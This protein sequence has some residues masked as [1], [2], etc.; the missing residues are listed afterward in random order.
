MAVAP[1]RADGVPRF[2]PGAD[3][4]LD[5]EDEPS[6]GAQRVSRQPQQRPRAGRNRRGCPPTRSR[7]T[8]GGVA[9]V[10][11][12]LAFDQFV[13]DIPGP[14]LGDHRRGQV[15]SHQSPRIRRDERSAQPGA[16]SGI[17]HI[18]ALRLPRHPI[19]PASPRPAPAHGTTAGRAWNRSWPRSCRRSPRRTRPMPAAA[20]RDRSRQPACAGRWDCPAPRSATLRR[21]RPPCRLHRACSAL[22]PAVSEL[23]D[24]SAST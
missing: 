22:S 9:Q 15:D 4:L 1:V 21:L 3:Q 8:P 5:G 11:R 7:R 6:A 14:R 18:E 2:G 20:H 13:V 12:Q 24:A 19:P 10:G 16:A 23:R 17:E